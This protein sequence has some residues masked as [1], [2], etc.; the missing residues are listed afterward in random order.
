[1]DEQI[2][3]KA[4]DLCDIKNKLFEAAFNIKFVY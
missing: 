1:M 3:Y 4:S 2:S